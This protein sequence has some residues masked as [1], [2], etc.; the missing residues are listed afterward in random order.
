MLRLLATGE[1]VSIPAAAAAAGLPGQRAEQK[2]RSWPEV[3][4]DDRGQVAG[5]WGLAFS[6]MPH[7]IRRAGTGFGY[8]GWRRASA[9]SMQARIPDMTGGGRWT[10]ST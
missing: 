4:W 6:G 1:P 10:S 3:F 9:R 5:F 8:L 2:L 7:R